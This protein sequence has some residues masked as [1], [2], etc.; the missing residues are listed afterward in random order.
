M[1]EQERTATPKS[2]GRLTPCDRLSAQG[3]TRD[4]PIIRRR[5]NDRCVGSTSDQSGLVGPFNLSPGLRR[6]RASLGD[7]TRGARECTADQF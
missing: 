4:F 3:N 6:R 2:T 7:P 5:A 1:V